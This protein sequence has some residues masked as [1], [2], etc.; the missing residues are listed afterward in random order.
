[1]DRCA[2]TIE[3]RHLIKDCGRNRTAPA[4]RSFWPVCFHSKSIIIVVVVAVAVAMVILV[5]EIHN[6]NSS[7]NGKSNSNC[8]IRHQVLRNSARP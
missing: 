2:R 7:S 6:D 5:S 4:E 1:M 3:I 8:D